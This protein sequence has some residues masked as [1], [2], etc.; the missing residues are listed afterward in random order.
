LEKLI[1]T[2][3]ETSQG[4]VIPFSLIA[5]AIRGRR[6]LPHGGTEVKGYYEEKNKDPQDNQQRN[7]ALV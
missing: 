5:K 1:D 2:P 6:F 4:D 3:L 7:T